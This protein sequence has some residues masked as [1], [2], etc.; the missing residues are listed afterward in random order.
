MRL[1]LSAGSLGSRK[2]GLAGLSLAAPVDPSL[3]LG[4]SWNSLTD[5]QYGSYS[6]NSYAGSVRGRGA[7]A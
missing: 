6:E 5:W 4:L 1:G 3:G 2:A 7:A